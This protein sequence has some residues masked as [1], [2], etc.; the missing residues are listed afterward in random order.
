MKNRNYNGLIKLTAAVLTA[1][2]ALTA[3]AAPGTEG[4]NSSIA[5]DIITSEGQETASDSPTAGQAADYLMQAA[6]KYGRASERSDVLAG[7][8]E[9]EAVTWIQLL[10]LAGRAFGELPA[11]EGAA[12]LMASPSVNLSSVPEWAKAELQNLANG[13]ILAPSDLGQAEQTEISAE[14]NTSVDTEKPATMKDLENLT[15]R[16]H[17]RF[18]TSLNDD[19]YHTVNK[20]LFDR[21]E[22][23]E[24]EM[25]A[26]GASTVTA[27]TNRQLHELILE[28]TES[29]NEYPTG[30]SEQKIRDLY[31]SVLDTELRNREGIKPLEKYFSAVDNARDYSELNAAIAL[32]VNE[33][34]NSGNGLFPMIAVADTE[35]SSRYIMQ[36]LTMPANL[37]LEDY[38]NEDSEVL[39]EY[40]ESIIRQ[41]MVAGD[42]LQE[43][44]RLA[45]AII[46]ME[47]ELAGQTIDLE[48]LGDLQRKPKRY[49]PECL[50][51]LMPQAR[52]S[53]L[54]TAIGLSPD[55][56]MQAFDEKQFEAFAGWFTPENLELF[57]AYQ[58]MA[59]L[60]GFSGYLSE[61]LAFEFYYGQAAD[62]DAANSAVQMFLSE[63]LGEL[64]VERY[65]SSESK[66]GIEE[67]AGMMID[68]FKDRIRRLDWMEVNTKQEALKKL[69]NI[70]ILIGY[71]D[72]W[73]KTDVTIKSRLD[74]GSYFDNAAAVS[75]WQWKQMVERLKK[76]VD[77]RRF[78]LAAY[79]VNAAASRNT[80]TIIFPAG[81]LQAPFYDPNASFEENLGAIGTTI[82]HEIT[83]MFDDGG[84]Q[85]DAAGNIRN[86]W[87]EHDNTYFKELCRKAEAYYDGYEALPGISVSGAETLSENIAD[88]GGVACSLEV[89]SKM[90][91]PDYDAFFRSYAGQWAR[92]GSYDDLA[93]MAS[94]DFHAPNRLRCNRVLAN[95][96]EFMDTYHVKPG[97]GMYVAPEERIKIW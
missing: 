35:D 16:F 2:I 74:G 6:G 89:L 57:K 70:T 26:G 50:D 80:N 58:K 33:L 45:N 5:A 31:L 72:E 62:S 23:P 79:T 90:E 59:L 75:A 41:L 83:H 32:A 84:A 14:Q 97:D 34:G 19:F 71:P 3:C 88:I 8:Q 39:K 17:A 13:G 44:E 66:A 63:E 96:Q 1:S 47:R 4:I 15:S 60:T 87:S 52:P 78:P 9:E 37:S 24:G 77:S 27:N 12:K 46:Q 20:E 30:S 85:Y 95:F 48:E 81:I 73:Q 68:V 94:S 51:A 49:T 11:P 28:L 76:P 18:G 29:G 7:F 92:L 43:A 93:E 86:W 82:A 64:Y 36:L 10:V 67:M 54:L 25:F 65:F 22:I 61:E 53:E 40:R 69:D 21:L 55:V 56:V 91:N 42:S 38:N